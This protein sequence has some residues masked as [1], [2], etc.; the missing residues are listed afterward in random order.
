MVRLVIGEEGK[1]LSGIVLLP[2]KSTDS[3]PDACWARPSVDCVSVMCPDIAPVWEGAIQH[4]A[5]KHFE[6]GGQDLT[7]LLARHLQLSQP[8]MS[9]DLSTVEMLKEKFAVVPE[10]QLD[11]ATSEEACPTVEHTLPDGQVRTCTSN[12]NQ[13]LAS[14]CCV[15][16]LK[17]DN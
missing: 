13:A 17:L 15:Y 7:A 10:D 12:A 14:S 2:H 6:I 8:H 16:L 4:N 3:S 5:V 11:Y 1:A 9:L